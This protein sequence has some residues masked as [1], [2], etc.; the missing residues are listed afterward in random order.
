M[1]TTCE[2]VC[3]GVPAVHHLL[4][5][6]T[7]VPLCL[8]ALGGRVAVIFAHFVKVCGARPDI[9]TRVGG[10]RACGGGGCVLV[11][12]RRQDPRAGGQR[13][14]EVTGAAVRGC[15]RGYGTQGAP[16]TLVLQK[17]RPAIPAYRSSAQSLTFIVLHQ[18]NPRSNT[19]HVHEKHNSACECGWS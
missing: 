1:Q 13:W 17:K 3:V 16:Q 6:W 12:V 7:H 10:G 9:L 4:M 18:Q 2:G 14:I 15:R 11:R 19:P 8:H 5:R